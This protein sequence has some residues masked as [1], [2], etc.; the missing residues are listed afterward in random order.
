VNCDKHDRNYVTPD[1]CQDC[2]IDELAAMTKERDELKEYIKTWRMT[3][4]DMTTT[5]ARCSEIAETKQ[6]QYKCEA[7]EASMRNYPKLEESYLSQHTAAR[8]LADA[9]RKE[10]N[11]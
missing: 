1:R 10:F 2:L 4:T 11:L 8:E 6:H 3:Y 7:A 5:A 9:I